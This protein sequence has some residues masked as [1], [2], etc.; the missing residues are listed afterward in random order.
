MSKFVKTF[1]FAV[2]FSTQPELGLLKAQ[3]CT[4]TYSTAWCG[5]CPSGDAG[6][7][8]SNNVSYQVWGTK[9]ETWC[10]YPA[11]YCEFYQCNTVSSIT[12]SLDCNGNYYSTQG[13]ICCYHWV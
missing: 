3:P 11:G 8:Q 13:T 9:T 6:C 1:L 12:A 10:N 7:W 2:L 4:T 5:D